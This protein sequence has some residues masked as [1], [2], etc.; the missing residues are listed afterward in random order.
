MIATY[1][2]GLLLPVT[3]VVHAQW[4]QTLG[5]GGAGFG[6]RIVSPSVTSQH[7]SRYIA[8]TDLRKS[9]RRQS[10]ASSD[11]SD[12]TSDYQQDQS[13][14]KLLSNILQVPMQRSYRCTLRIKDHGQKKF[15]FN[16]CLGINWNF[17]TIV[18]PM[19]AVITVV[20]VHK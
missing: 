18:M 12:S 7:H 5:W 14:M 19:S 2:L 20:T 15:L 16:C 4:A 11:L 8:Q 3:C 17:Q 6:K 9:D 1:F 10:L 13:L